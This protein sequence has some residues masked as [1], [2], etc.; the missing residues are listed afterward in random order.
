MT[1]PA[2]PVH[3]IVLDSSV[4]VGYERVKSPGDAAMH[5]TQ[6]W[7]GGWPLVSRD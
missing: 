7:V 5:E 3:P 1:G 6:A 4:L 2:S